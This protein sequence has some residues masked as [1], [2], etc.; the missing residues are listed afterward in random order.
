MSETYI[1]D[2]ILVYFNNSNSYLILDTKTY[3]FYKTF[4][5]NKKKH[6]YINALDKSYPINLKTSFLI[7][8]QTYQ[9]KQILLILFLLIMTLKSSQIIPNLYKYLTKHYKLDM[10][11]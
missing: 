10:I 1:D 11:Q 8:L 6:E 4:K 2:Y 3:P 7:R 9:K 5:L